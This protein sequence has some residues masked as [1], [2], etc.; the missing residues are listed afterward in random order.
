MRGIG[1]DGGPA[2]KAQLIS[3]YGIALD[4]AG[5]LYIAD[6]DAHMVRRVAVDGTIS[7]IAGTGAP[8]F[9]GDGGPSTAAKL[10]YPYAVA[11]DGS[12]NLFIADTENSRVRKVTTAGII[13]TAIGTGSL[14]FT[15]SGGP[16]PQIS[17]AYPE[18]LVFDAAGNLYI[19]EWGYDR[20]LKM[21][22]AGTVTVFAGTGFIGFDGDSGPETAATFNGPRGLAVDPA[23]N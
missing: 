14:N 20:V 15:P 2:A 1:G 8:G 7:T 17:I 13:S 22:Q 3:P 12:G 23:G 21:S 18:G 19:S 6:H 5:N 10:F 16:G 9:A 4:L 11:L